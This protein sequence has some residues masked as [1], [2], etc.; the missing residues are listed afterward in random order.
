MRTPPAVVHRIDRPR[1]GPEG[2]ESGGRRGTGA[3]P[4]RVSD[5]TDTHP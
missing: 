4:P 1:I 2:I 5:R 3:A